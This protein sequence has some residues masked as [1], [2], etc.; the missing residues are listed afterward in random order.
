[1]KKI[2]LLILISLW[3]FRSIALMYTKHG[4]SPEQ[5]HRMY[6]NTA[7]SA[8]GC[9]QGIAHTIQDPLVFM[10]SAGIWIWNQTISSES[11]DQTLHH[12]ATQLETMDIHTISSESLVHLVSHTIPQILSQQYSDFVHLNAQEQSPTV[13]RITLDIIATMPLAALG[14]VKYGVKVKDASPP[15]VN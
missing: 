9:A 15:F 14:A 2:L 5:E 3:G 12:I 4:I 13:C 8:I 6:T 10:W 7:N 11:R 1:M